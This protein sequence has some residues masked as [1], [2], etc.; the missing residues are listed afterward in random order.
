[1]L[2]ELCPEL[3]FYDVFQMPTTEKLLAEFSTTAITKT[4][5]FPGR[6]YLTPH[7]LCFHSSSANSASL[8][9]T[10]KEVKPV[11]VVIQ[12]PQVTLIRIQA[13]RSPRKPLDYL[14]T[15]HPLT[16]LDKKP[17]VRNQVLE[18]MTNDGKTHRFYQ[19]TEFIKAMN[20]AEFLWRTELEK[21]QRAVPQPHNYMD[22]PP[23]FDANAPP[24]YAQL[25]P[26]EGEISMPSAPAAS[27]GPAASAPP[28]PAEM[29]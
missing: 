7:Y 10:G 20:L 28:A 15:I 22:E 2:I 16:E 26:M 3:Q 19:F 8:K 25:Y 13:A 4:M 21:Q 12:W 6:V 29:P 9:A 18:V 1:M 14:P 23:P 24:S 27:T 11:K 17:G 5:L